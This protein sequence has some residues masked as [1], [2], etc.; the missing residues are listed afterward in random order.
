MTHDSHVAKT[1]TVKNLFDYSLAGDTKQR[2]TELH[3]HSQRLRGNMTVAQT[4]AHCTSGIEM[5]MGVINPK[6]PLQFKT[7]FFDLLLG[8]G[9]A[10]AP[11][12]LAA[13]LTPTVWTSN[14]RYPQPC[15]CS[16]ACTQ[17]T[18]LLS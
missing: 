13:H 16:D 14:H 17:T 1:A 7:E 8:S 2:I 10:D 15:V 6:R 5:A 3:H 12:R 18:G 11:I 4:L 9:L